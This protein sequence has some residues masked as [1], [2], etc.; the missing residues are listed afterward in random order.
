MVYILEFERPV[1][2]RSRF[3]IGY[4]PDERTY[5]SRMKAHV[6][7]RGAAFTR[8]A[9]AQG[10]KFKTVVIIPDGTRQDERRL[11]SWKKAAQVVRALRNKGY[12]AQL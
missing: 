11:K 5:F 4:S 8:A 9:V 12:G 10:I 1:G 6:K 2:G 3:Y 7:G